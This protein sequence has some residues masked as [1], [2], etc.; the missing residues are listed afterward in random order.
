[1]TASIVRAKTFTL[2]QEWNRN[3]PFRGGSGWRGW[4]G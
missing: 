3:V 4:G 1:L 2:Y